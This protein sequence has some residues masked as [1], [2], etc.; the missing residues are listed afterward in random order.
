ML[1]AARHIRGPALAGRVPRRRR[2]AALDDPL[3]KAFRPKA[4]SAQLHRP[5]RPRVAS[6]LAASG[7]AVALPGP[8]ASGPERQRREANRDVGGAGRRARGPGAAGG[9][10][11]SLAQTSRRGSR[12]GRLLL[13]SNS[14]LGT[15]ERC[16]LR[17]HTR[18]LLAPGGCFWP[19]R[20]PRQGA[21]ETR[22]PGRSWGCA[23][24]WAPLWNRALERWKSK[25]AE[26]AMPTLVGFLVVLAL[27][28]V[29]AKVRGDA[30]G[31][32]VRPEPWQV[33][34]GTSPGWAYY[35]APEAL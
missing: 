28:V 26:S 33:G 1:P 18:V 2:R 35:L 9:A 32:S 4:R 12:S 8:A 17:G 30:F 11:G 3:P 23:L 10:A 7:N 19:P 31:I 6:R 20:V 16:L 22:R 13:L 25:S 21:P 29:G 14:L 34:S 27:Q 24:L 15:L 5:D